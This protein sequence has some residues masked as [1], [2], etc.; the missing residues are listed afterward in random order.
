MKSHTIAPK[1]IYYLSVAAHITPLVIYAYLFPN[2]IQS[3]DV[4]IK[5]LIMGIT[6]IFVLWFIF[7]FMFK[8]IFLK[9]DTEKKLVIYG[10]ILFS[11][12]AA[13]EQINSVRKK[14]GGFLFEISINSKKYHFIAPD[15][16]EQNLLKMLGK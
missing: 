10:S 8:F 5:F 6:S 7:G 14:L 9:I 12:E 11:H 1:S 16:D 4:T 13:F 2:L 3:L 15:L